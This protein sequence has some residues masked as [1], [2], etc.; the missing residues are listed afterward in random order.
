MMPAY[1]ATFIKA[2][3]MCSIFFKYIATDFPSEFK[4]HQ[5]I[6]TC[7]ING[8]QQS[9]DGS[10]YCKEH[11]LKLVAS[12]LVTKSVLPRLILQE[13]SKLPGDA[14]V[15]KGICGN[16]LQASQSAV[17]WAKQEHC[18]FFC[19]IR[20]WYLAA[21]PKRLLTGIGANSVPSCKGV[22][23]P[24]FHWLGLSHVSNEKTKS[25]WMASLITDFAAMLSSAPP[26]KSFSAC[27]TTAIIF[28]WSSYHVLYNFNFQLWMNS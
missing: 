8:T 4:W 11:R 24:H 1:S 22:T 2:P 14:F 15:Y 28:N 23:L 9:M 18:M 6:A 13:F 16:Y 3:K 5:V 10:S 7:G 19:F 26:G 27:S 17:Q 12:L 21:W 25:R 20:N